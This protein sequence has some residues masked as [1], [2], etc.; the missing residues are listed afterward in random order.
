MISLSKSLRRFSVFLLLYGCVERFY[1]GENEGIIIEGKRGVW[2]LTTLSPELWYIEDSARR[3][4]FVD[5][6]ANAL[7]KVGDTIF[8]VNSGTNTVFRFITSTSRVETLSVGMGRNPYSLAYSSLNNTLFVSNFLTNTISAFKGRVL[9]SEFRT[10]GNPEGMYTVGSRL[11]VSCT[12][13]Y[14]DMRGEIWIHDVFT[15]D[16]IKTLRMGINSQSVILDEDGDIYVLSTGDYSGRESYLFRI[17]ERYERIDSFFIGGYLGR[18]CISKKGYIFLVGW[19]GGVYRFNWVTERGEGFIIS[20]VSASSCA[21]KGDTLIITDF[22]ND[23]VIY[24]DFSGKFLKQ[25]YVGDGPIDVYA[26]EF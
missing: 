4:A 22:D 5:L 8:I 17:S 10:C 25:F 23:R 1:L 6:W 26:G 14:S 24:S 11:F 21:V 7:L 3:I 16:T 13:Y 15:F 12:N 20:D 19:Y 18:M 2:V 9:I